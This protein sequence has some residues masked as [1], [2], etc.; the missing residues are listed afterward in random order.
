MSKVFEFKNL[1][2]LTIFV[3]LICLI[4]FSFVFTSAIF[5]GLVV[6]FIRIWICF[7]WFWGRFIDGFT[8]WMRVVVGFGFSFLLIAIGFF[9]DSGEIA[10]CSIACFRR[11]VFVRLFRYR[12]FVV[13]LRVLNLFLFFIFFFRLFFVIFFFENI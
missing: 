12:F 7:G 3:G 9:C 4:R 2:V 11:F 10:A 8:G 13:I 1:L 6:L 5:L